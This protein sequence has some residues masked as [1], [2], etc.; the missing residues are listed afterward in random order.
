MRAPG[1]YRHGKANQRGAAL[2]IMIAI[3]VVGFAALLV[4]EL[5]FS[6]INNARQQRTSDALAKA[7]SALLGRAVSDDNMPGSLPCPDLM[8]NIVGTNVPD[9][10]IADLFAGNDCPSYIGRLP[11]RTLKLP[12]L[13]DGSGERLWY[14]LSPAFRDDSSAQ[15]LNS[16]TKGTLLVYNADGLSLQTKAGY[17]AVAV[18]F[19]PG[20]PVGS[21]VR[22]TVAQQN[23][24]A[25]YLDIANSRDNAVDV[26]P[27]IAGTKSD[28]FNDRLLLITTQDLMPLV[29]QRVAGVVKKA[30]DDYYLDSDITPANRYY[31]WADTIG[32][33]PT[34]AADDGVTR[35][36]LPDNAVAGPLPTINWRADSPP[37][38]F[39]DNQW[40]RLIYYSVA[41]SY[42]ASHSLGTLTVDG[43]T[44]VRVLFFM[45]GTPIGT[46]TRWFNKLDDYLEDPENN[47]HDAVPNAVPPPPA[48][49]ASATP[50]DDYY[51]TPTSQANDRDRLYWLS[52][53]STWNP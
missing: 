28:T 3:L 38:W 25:N 15:P 12:D 36:W 10:G 39:F 42:S 27:F 20:S 5:S 7:K 18:I 16:N 29:E 17:S 34:Y 48:V 19:A 30:L 35:G 33:N 6:A 32:V 31:P 26:G 51:I 9:D 1:I 21:Q 41:N 52:S 49:T 50:P 53:S 4:G 40:N 44:G 37:L 8:T 13:R 45:P 46:L 24:A 11:W 14:A 2:M 47:E 22:S 23:S 43:N